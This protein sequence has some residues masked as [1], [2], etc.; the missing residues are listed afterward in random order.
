MSP[1]EVKLLLDTVK[2]LKNRVEKLENEN[3]NL[4]LGIAQ[5][6]M[7]WTK[8]FQEPT[9]QWLTINEFVSLLIAEGIYD[10]AVKRDRKGRDKVRFIQDKIRRDG[11]LTMHVGIDKPEFGTAVWKQSD[12]TVLYHRT[13]A[14]AEFVQKYVPSMK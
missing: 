4:S 12:R 14:V 7:R 13:H 3:R 8:T 5:I 11:S 10:N 6:N 9:T 1:H 2:Q